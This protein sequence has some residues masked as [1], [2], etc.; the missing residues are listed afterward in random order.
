VL[1][2]ASEANAN[3][4]AMATHGTSALRHVLAGST[5]LGVLGRAEIPVILVRPF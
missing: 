4:I 2:A 3:A 1:R 5:A